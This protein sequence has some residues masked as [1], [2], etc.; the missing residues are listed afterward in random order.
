MRFAQSEATILYKNAEEH[1]QYRAKPDLRISRCP[2]LED[3]AH[4]LRKALEQRISEYT[5][6]L[7]E[8][9]ATSSALG[10]RDSKIASLEEAA[11]GC[12]HRLA[13]LSSKASKTSSSH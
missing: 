12:G 7:N 8:L 13:D 11:I 4:D 6:V 9:G 10:R 1:E 5:E 2:G 3:R